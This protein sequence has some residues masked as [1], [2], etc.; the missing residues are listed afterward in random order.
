MEQ[1]ARAKADVINIIIPFIDD[2]K[3][4]RDTV[5]RGEVLNSDDLE[6][7]KMIKDLINKFYGQKMSTTSFR[8][9]SD[10]D[11]DEDEVLP[12]LD[13]DEEYKEIEMRMIGLNYDNDDDDLE[14]KIESK[15]EITEPTISAKH[16]VSKTTEHLPRIWQMT[17]DYSD[18]DDKKNDKKSVDDSDHIQKSDSV[19]KNNPKDVN[20]KSTPIKDN[21]N[22][23]SKQSDE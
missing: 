2:I 19:G 17:I 14:S 9:I 1:Q 10:N 18:D 15:I 4:I 5:N 21:I 23:V 6:T 8:Y 20:L 3:Q 13:I 7:V 22:E 16:R 11:N 12:G